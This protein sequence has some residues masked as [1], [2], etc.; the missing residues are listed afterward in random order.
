MNYLYGKD[1]WLLKNLNSKKYSELFQFM[2][3]RNIAYSNKIYQI[4][5][6]NFTIMRHRDIIHRLDK[7]FNSNKTTSSFV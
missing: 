1:S 5:M 3:T 4:W 6:K 2:R 7:F